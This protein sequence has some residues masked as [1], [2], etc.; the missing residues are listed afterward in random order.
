MARPRKNVDAAEV[1]KLRLEGLSFRDI[2]R[3]MRVGR[4]TT[5]RVYQAAIASLA[6][7]QNRR[8][9]HES[10]RPAET[11]AGSLVSMGNRGPQTS[12]YGGP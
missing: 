8:T 11:N 2:A 1:L 10:K 5:H 4:G 7:S 9:R 12:T 6:A 3:R